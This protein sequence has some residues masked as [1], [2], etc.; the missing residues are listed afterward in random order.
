[1]NHQT[2]KKVGNGTANIGNFST[3]NAST[4]IA[5]SFQLQQ[6]RQLYRKK[7]LT[8]IRQVL[9]GD[10]DT[11]LRREKLVA[12][13]K[14]ILPYTQGIKQMTKTPQ[15]MIRLNMLVPEL[16]NVR[17]PALSES[18]LQFLLDIGA[19]PN[20]SFIKGKNGTKETLLNFLL[21][22]LYENWYKDDF[23]Q[24]T[25]EEKIARKTSVK[26]LFLPRTKMLLEYEFTT[27]DKIDDYQKWMSKESSDQLDQI[28]DLIRQL[29]RRITGTS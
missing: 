14:I 13:R 5:T 9:F 29:P 12:R 21:N 7:M 15:Q 28:R 4:H 2:L 19:D 25:Q 10:E 20:H 22:F 23:G 24:Q 8:N 1:M 11:T 3:V 16:I 27:K 6:I 18:I 26:K 17:P